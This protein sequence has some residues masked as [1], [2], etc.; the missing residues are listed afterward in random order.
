M[1]RI[2]AIR[3]LE[4]FTPEP[5]EA[6]PPDR[7]RDLNKIINTA[8]QSGL[9]NAP[10]LKTLKGFRAQLQTSGA[11]S[12]DPEVVEANWNRLLAGELANA[13][14]DAKKA[15]KRQAFDDLIENHIKPR[16]KALADGVTIVDGAPPPGDEARA[17][18]RTLLAGL[19]EE[20]LD[21][22]YFRFQATAESVLL[23]AEGLGPLGGGTNLARITLN[24]LHWWMVSAN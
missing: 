7:L 23:A 5:E 9:V 22:L 18:G 19:T 14:E 6:K 12:L 13:I 3:Y 15:T 20:K 10:E 24:I 21:E 8:E 17:I 16:F 4:T 2:S 1:K 11:N